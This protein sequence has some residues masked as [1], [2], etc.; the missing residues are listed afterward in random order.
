MRKRRMNNEGSI[1]FRKDRN[2][3]VY[4]YTLNNKRKTVSAKTQKE[5]KEKMKKINELIFT[6]KMIEKTPKTVEEIGLIIA[7]NKLELNQ[8]KPSS[9]TRRLYSISTL[10]PILD[11][12]I[13]RIEE[14]DILDI[15]KYL[16]KYSN[17]VIEKSVIILKEIIR[18]ALEK[19]Y[20][21][22]DIMKNIPKPKSIKKDREI[23]ALTIDEQKKFLKIIDESKYSIIY[24]IQLNTGMRIGEVLNLTKED[25][26]FNKNLIRVNKTVTR[27]ING[28]YIFGKTTKTAN[29]VRDIPISKELKEILKRYLITLDTEYLFSINNKPLHYLRLNN[30]LY[31]LNNKYNISDTLSTHI[32]RHTFATRCIES[33]MPAVI[34]AKILGHSDVSITLNTYTSVFDEYQNKYLENAFNYINKLFGQ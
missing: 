9:Y 25:I 14:K 22:K 4:E 7:K 21:N 8:I 28:K 30:D 2:C 13:S 29:G 18:Y 17:S 27:D 32:F 19:N 3:W 15:Y 10:K 12:P 11:I 26:D 6:N 24:K 33:G 5:L 16:T 1:F 20:I 23:K 31:R 34:L